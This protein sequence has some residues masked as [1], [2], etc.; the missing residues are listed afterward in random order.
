MRLSGVPTF[1]RG[2]NRLI[3]VASKPWQVLLSAAAVIAVVVVAAALADLGSIL[4]NGWVLATV[5]VLSLVVGYVAI[6]VG[7]GPITVFTVRWFLQTLWRGG[8]GM[9]HVLPLLLVAV[10]FF[11]MTAETWQSIGRL[12]GLPLVLSSLL[13]VGVAVAFLVRRGSTDVEELGRFADTEAVR[14]ALP[15]EL[16]PAG[17]LRYTTPAL[18]WG[19]RLNLT[20]I[21]VLG[22]VFVAAVVGLAIFVFFVV[23]GLF[24]ITAQVAGAWSAGEPD[25]WWQ[26]TMAGHGYALTAEHLRVSAFLGVF[27]A[28]YF[29]VSSASDRDLAKSLSSA[30]ED[31]VRSCLAVRAVYRGSR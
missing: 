19:E 31:H 21:S 27:S 18:S 11:F 8:S 30:A 23:F 16:R 1:I 17:S 13:L 5:L 15:A 9:L 22:K 2:E 4:V 10:T 20:V 6:A 28:L 25:I 7:L 3:R 14:E 12:K 29:I 26:F 24:T